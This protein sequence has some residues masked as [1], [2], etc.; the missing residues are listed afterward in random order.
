MESITFH[1]NRP[2]CEYAKQ[3]GK[4][5]AMI[6][7]RCRSTRWQQGKLLSSDKVTTAPI[8]IHL[9]WVSTRWNECGVPPM[10]GIFER[11]VFEARA[12]SHLLEE[13]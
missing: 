5:T 8:N 10:G 11:C 13:A 2:P 3:S 12:G 4:P 1:V 7:L 9:V 6:V